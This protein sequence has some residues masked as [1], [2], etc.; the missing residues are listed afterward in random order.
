MSI[1]FSCE[2]CGKD[3]QTDASFAGK[4]CKCKQCGHVFVIP[5]PRT[6]ASS[7]SVKPVK[8]YGEPQPARSQPQ[9][10]PKPSKPNY[11]DEN[12]DPYGIDDPAPI[13]PRRATSP[14]PEEEEFRGPKPISMKPRQRNRSYDNDMGFFGGLPSLYYLISLGILA[15]TFV[16]ALIAPSV[17]GPIFLGAAI[18]VALVPLIY[19]GI[20]MLVV[21]FL[22]SVAQGLLCM[23]VPF[24]I[25]ALVYLI[26]RWDAMKGVFLSYVFGI[27]VIVGAVMTGVAIRAASGPNGPNN[28]NFAPQAQANPGFPGFQPP[29]FVPPPVAPPAVAPPRAVPPLIGAEPGD[30][31]AQNPPPAGQPS[32]PPRFQPPAPNFAPPQANDA[33]AVT[34]QV[35]G[36]VDKETEDAFNDKLKEMMQA[37]YGSYR[38]SGSGGAARKTIIV[39]PISDAKAFAD[40]INWAKVTGV[41]GRTINV[42]MTPLPAGERRPAGTDWTAQV[43]FDL[44]S[45]NLQRRKDAL[46]RISDTPP[47]EKKRVEIA[48]AIE[49]M[50]QDPDSFA[51]C[52][53]AKALAAWGG[54]ENVPALIEALHDPAFNVVWAVFDALERM[55]D[56]SS[57]EPV[58]AFLATQQNRNNAAKVL[59]AIGAPA[60]PA[61][62][63]YLTHGDVFV[64]MEAAH[65]LKEIGT[66]KCVPDLQGLIR[67]TNNQG[68]DAM[69]AGEALDTLGAPRFATPGR[70]GSR[71]S[72]LVPKGRSG[73]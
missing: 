22:E 13:P 12:D 32:V 58:A 68:L 17:G 20:G 31:L 24:S 37:Q 63:K 42:T 71:K 4:K 53:A 1:A 9:A 67:A 46:R 35:T 70:G 11:L 52:D 61:V 62:I 7:G 39:A 19:G 14:A 55:K 40:K 48:S 8:T 50:L 26:T 54:K 28:P 64:R 18:L 29:P 51:R 38:M 66:D 72:K 5:A 69:A 56:P 59:K 15:A 47:D 41:N 57:A 49:P 60:E 30:N 34:L 73:Q 21:P 33:D 2:N 36:L 6:S 25:Y 45:P 65:I 16:F 23:F 27:A 3:F 44:K 10:R 43:L